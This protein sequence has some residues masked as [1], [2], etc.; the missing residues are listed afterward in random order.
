[1]PAL[2]FGSSP[3]RQTFFPSCT[4]FKCE[5]NYFIIYLFIK[6]VLT[7]VHDTFNWRAALNGSSSSNNNNNKKKT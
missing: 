4:G 3:C 5:G 2:L 6:L 7:L 1:M